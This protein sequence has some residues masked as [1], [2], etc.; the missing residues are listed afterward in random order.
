MVRAL[1]SRRLI[2]FSMAWIVAAPAGADCPVPSLYPH[3]TSMM[4][5]DLRFSVASDKTHDVV[6]EPVR[7]CFSILN[8]SL[9]RLANAWSTSARGLVLISSVAPSFPATMSLPRA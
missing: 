4:I 3:A 9:L 1:L 8:P 7:I 2:A 5:G 6:G